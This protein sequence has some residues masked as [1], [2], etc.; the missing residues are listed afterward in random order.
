MNIA[1]YSKIDVYRAYS[2]LIVRFGTYRHCTIDVV[3]K[4]HHVERSVNFISSNATANFSI[5][6][7][8]KRIAFSFNYIKILSVAVYDLWNLRLRKLKSSYIFL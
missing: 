6:N 3:N 4:V 7:G 5:S 1:K 8:L 2:Y